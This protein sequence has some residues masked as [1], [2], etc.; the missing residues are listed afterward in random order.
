LT[1]VAEEL[2]GRHLFLTGGTGTVGRTLLD[3]LARCPGPFTATLLTRNAGAFRRDH[4]AQADL[5]W[6]RLVEGSLR[7]LPSLPDG[8]TDVIHAAADTH[9]GHGRAAWVE[10]IAG[11]TA[12]LLDAARGAGAGR[13]LLVSSGAVYGPQPADL[14]AIPEDYRGAPDPLLPG[15]TY[16]QAKRVAEQLCTI[17]HHE[18][19]LPTVIARLF[20][21]GSR[22][23]PRDGRYA[24]GD[25]VRDALA[26]GGAPI[27]VAGDGRAMRSYLSGDD[28]A[29]ALVT[30]LLRGEPGSAYNVGSDQALTVGELATRI[31]DRL[32]PGRAVAVAG[33]AGDGQRSRYVPDTARIGALGAA[34]RSD[35]DRVI[36][37]AAGRII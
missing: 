32:S 37:D 18:H 16:G 25:F 20:A 36:D 8:V 12:A 21:F 13:F 31:R 29:H 11:G 1:P 17:A 7:A 26:P 2:T 35:L 15:S 22:H 5:P 4:P 33:A 14:P 28:T 34:R 10:Q 27:R 6:L 9:L 23:I 24:L 19:G 30:A 3:W